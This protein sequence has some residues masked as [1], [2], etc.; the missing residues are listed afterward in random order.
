LVPDS[1]HHEQHM[2]GFT[3][4][5][6]P[7]RALAAAFVGA[8]LAAGVA[9]P[10]ARACDILTLE[11]IPAADDLQY[12]VWITDGAGNFV[13]TVRV[14]RLVGTFG[15]GNRAGRLSTAAGGG[16][17]GNYHWPYGKELE[18][19]P[20]WAYGRGVFYPMLVMQD[21]MEDWL[22]FHEASSSD[23]PYYC[24]PQTLAES[25]DMTTCA[26]EG[27]NSDK[28]V[29][30]PGGAVVPYPP[31]DD[32]TM[33]A[34]NDSASVSTFDAAN[35]LDAVTAATPLAGDLVTIMYD[36]SALPAGD[37]VAW[38]EVSRANDANDSWYGVA[39]PPLRPDPAPLPCYTDSLLPEFGECLHGQ[40]SVVWQAAF[41]VSG[42]P[43]SFVST[44]LDFAGYGDPV[45]A[46]GTLN[47]PDG[48]ITTGVDGT[49]AGRLLPM[50]GV[51]GDFRFGLSCNE[52]LCADNTAPSPVTM[53]AQVPPAETDGDD[54]ARA[55]L[56]L[57]HP[58]DDDGGRVTSYELR[59]AE[60]IAA[61]DA[62]TFGD[63]IPGPTVLP[64][65]PGTSVDVVLM[66]LRSRTTY[67]VGV[68]VQD[69]C[70]NWSSLFFFEV[71]TEAQEFTTVTPCGCR[72]VGADVAGGGAG[73]A[74][75]AL[76]SAA[77]ATA[78]GALV[79]GL[80]AGLRARRR[81]TS[82]RRE[83]RS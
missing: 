55:T 49:G 15:I 34:S 36:A 48:T 12:A 46:D 13:A 76:G 72:V 9:E 70:L 60:G 68:R 1:R 35:D 45:G 62:A 19:L 74:A 56:R 53:A 65:D 25:V 31:R 11:F 75:G 6:T 59:Y 16:F 32:L 20:V 5:W 3:T 14:T 51:G 26:S 66:P 79:I 2:N 63:G 42:G 21:G 67:T 43:D 39:N 44:T 28:G 27:F 57:V 47:G 23:E 41:T 4:A 10:A 22:G 80:G 17:K 33:V 29:F 7:A 81:V 78:L 38:I 8:A 40:P 82:P 77:G 58:A 61:L 52:D 30:D 64:G 69:E 73:G 37:Y 50:T 54:F 83:P 18:A 24:K 71:T